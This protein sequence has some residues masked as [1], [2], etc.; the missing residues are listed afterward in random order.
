M[1]G[2]LQSIRNDIWDKRVRRHLLE[3]QEQILATDITIDTRGKGKRR[4]FVPSVRIAESLDDLFKM[5]VQTFEE[6]PGPEDPLFFNAKGEPVASFRKSFSNLLK[7][8]D[9]LHDRQKRMRSTICLRHYYITR[10]IAD[11]VPYHV[12][13]LNVGTSVKMIEKTYSHVVPMMF[14]DQLRKA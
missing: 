3:D 8:A 2:V 9:L 5:W 13:A 6:P 10:Q 14:A 12:V 11:G 4:T 1:K 7:S